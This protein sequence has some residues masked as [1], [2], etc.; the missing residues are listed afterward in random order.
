MKRFKTALLLCGVCVGSFLTPARADIRL[1]GLFSDHMVLQREIPIPVWGWAE[2]GAKVSVKLAGQETRAVADAN[3][4]WRVRLAPLPAT[5]QPLTMTITDGVTTSALH[6]VLIGDVW[7]CSGQSNMELP[8]HMCNSPEDVRGAQFPLIRNFNV[9][10]RPSVE[11]LDD[12]MEGTKFGAGLR[13]WA[14]CSPQSASAFLS[15]VG[16]YFARKVHQETGV[17]IGLINA[18]WG[19]VNIETFLTP[20]GLESVP[21]LAPVRNQLAE[22]M[23]K[24]RKEVAEKLPA[25]EA[26]LNATRKALAENKPLP[27]PPAWPRHPSAVA[28]GQMFPLEIYCLYNG[29]IHPLLPFAIKGALW[30]QGESNGTDGDL[31]YHKMRAL[32]GGWRTAWGQG[33]FPFYY[34]QLAAYRKPATDPAAAGDGWPA[35]RCAQTKA[36]SIPRTGMAVAIDIGD[37]DDIHPKN[38]KDVGERLALWALKNDYGRS[39]LECSGPIF[40]TLKVE[41]DKARIIFD[42]TGSGLMVGRKEGKAP[43]REVKDGKLQRFAVAGA[44]GKWCWAEALIDGGTVVVSSTNVPQPVAV[45]YAYSS[46]PEGCNL[47]NR[48]GLPAS[49]FESKIST[50]EAVKTD[51]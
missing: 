16:F 8:L 46:N 27:P 17:P 19:G 20:E 25:A 45:R 21:E 10:K 5:C 23:A 2:P 12:L 43:V 30:Y 41:G 28:P 6:D 1:V 33:D 48:E 4:C 51:K 22:N 31:Y 39:T 44:D 11:P 49:P 14:V 7:L 29:M 24:Y 42:H 38:K 37:A 40:K 35:L 50:A 13:E 36:L 34:V 3:G 32:I 9:P 26:C 15:A 18:L 47:Y